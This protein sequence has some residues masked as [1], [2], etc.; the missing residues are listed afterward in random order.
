MSPINLIST[1]YL[2]VAA[3]A[4]VSPVSSPEPSGTS[5]DP[6][7][8]LETHWY[9]GPILA[10]DAAAAV[11]VLG[12]SYAEPEWRFGQ[13]L[14]LTSWVVTPAIIHLA[15][16]QVGR[17]VASAS[18]RLVLP[19]V[20]FKV[21][22]SFGDCED[23]FIAADEAFYGLF[24]GIGLASVIDQFLA[25]DSHPKPPPKVTG[26]SFDGIALQPSAGSDQLMIVGAGR[27]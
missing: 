12:S 5:S 1:S 15:H 9:G 7:V 8:E 13:G 2:L 19:I 21:G 11:I 3:A 27:F 23:C 10:A 24:I 20:G 6:Q 26:V 16:G 18:M 14:A 17:S 22:S 4:G 25:F